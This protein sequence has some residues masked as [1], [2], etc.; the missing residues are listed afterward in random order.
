MT[1][2]ER[3]AKRGVVFIAALG[4]ATVVSAQHLITAVPPAPYRAPAIEKAASVTMQLPATSPALRIALPEPSAS[5]RASLRSRNAT[6]GGNRGKA[7][8]QKGLAVAFPR[9][10]PGDLQQVALSSLQW[11]SLRTRHTKERCEF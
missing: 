8:E 2:V 7:T 6:V 9:N 11:Q 3:P 5:E 4:A 10:I 1:K